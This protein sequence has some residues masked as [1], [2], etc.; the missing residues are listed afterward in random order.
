M[1]IQP[2]RPIPTPKIFLSPSYSKFAV[3]CDCNSKISKTYEVFFSEWKV[4]FLE[5]KH[6]F[7]FFQSR[8]K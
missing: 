3:E 5:E 4:G 1:P 6:D 2:K 8:L 7:N